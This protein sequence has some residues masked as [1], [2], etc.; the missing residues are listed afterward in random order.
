M[1]FIYDGEL[2]RYCHECLLEAAEERM[3]RKRDR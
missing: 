2:R 3:F 1:Y